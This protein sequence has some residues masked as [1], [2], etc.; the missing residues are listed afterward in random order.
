M[1]NQRNL[2]F[3]LSAFGLLFF[4]LFVVYS[5]GLSGRFFFDDFA[6]IVGIPAIKIEQ[7]S[8]DSLLNV[9]GSGISGPLGRPISMLSFAANY[10]FSGVDPYWFKLTNVLIHGV[11]GVLINFLAMLVLRASGDARDKGDSDKRC[12]VAAA[13]ALAWSRSADAAEYPPALQQD[14]GG[15][16]PDP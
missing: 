14:L 10:Y 8:V 1:A 11:N 2:V 3:R 6:N 9:W 12:W 13:L 4:L 16:G 15:N 5:N 7:V